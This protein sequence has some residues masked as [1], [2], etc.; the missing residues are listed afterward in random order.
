MRIS[1]RFNGPPGSGNGGWSAG[2]FAVEAGA[3]I[4]GPALEVTLRVPPPLET[5]LTFAEGAVHDGDTLVATVT[6]AEG[7]IPAVT[8][9]GLAVAVEA[10]EAYEGFTRHPFPTCYVCGPERPDGLR[11]FSGPLPDGRT[12]APWVVPAEADLR[13]VWAALDCPGGWTA[14]RNGRTYVLGRIAVVA[15][16]LPEPGSTCVV[17]GAATGFSG[18]K[19]MVL[20]TVYAADGTPVAKARATWI[21]TT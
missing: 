3:R 16:A 8:P 13:V 14:L 18:R 12:A 20:S 10:A 1:E 21:A 7:D 11:I 17:V 4:G 2:A 19:A 15:D 6:A 5:E 9:V